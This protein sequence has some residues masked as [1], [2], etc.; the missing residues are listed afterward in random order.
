MGKNGVY[1]LRNAISYNRHI[2]ARTNGIK[3]Y[4]T[5]PAL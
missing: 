5:C 4:R 1:L 3:K 2:A